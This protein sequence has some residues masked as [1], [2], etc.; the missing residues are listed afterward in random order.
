ML[1][2]LNNSIISVNL[3]KFSAYVRMFLLGGK[4]SVNG[5][6]VDGHSANFLNLTV[7][8]MKLGDIPR[9]CHIIMPF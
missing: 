2:H 4:F 3:K 7:L 6:L 9:K 8:L 5:N 1:D